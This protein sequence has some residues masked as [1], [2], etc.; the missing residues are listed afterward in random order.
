LEIRIKKLAFF[1]GLVYNKKD[2]E[3]NIRRKF[4]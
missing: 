2:S 3:I 4:I 1:V